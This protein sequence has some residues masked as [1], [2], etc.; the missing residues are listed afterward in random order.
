[1]AT[2][3]GVSL[4]IPETPAAWD[5]L[6]S[7][8]AQGTPVTCTGLDRLDPVKACLLMDFLLHDP[9]VS[10]PVEPFTSLMTALEAHQDVSLWDL[11]P[12][13]QAQTEE[14]GAGR[15]HCRFFAMCHGYGRATGT[16][17][18]WKAVMTRLA[19]E[20]EERSHL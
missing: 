10:A 17:A 14:R 11:L 16:C 4:P 13:G 7:L 19:S 12:H 6:S 3:V 2:R 20:L 1:M 8:C 5:Q 9:D 18:A 15:G